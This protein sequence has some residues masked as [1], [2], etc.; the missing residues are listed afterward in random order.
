MRDMSASNLGISDLPMQLLIG[1]C[2]IS[3]ASPIFYSAYGDISSS[4]TEASVE[5]VIMEML[6]KMELLLAGDHGSR[7][8]MD[9]DLQGFGNV[10]IDRVSIGGPLKGGGQ[11]FIISYVLTDGSRGMFSLD[12]PYPISSADNSTLTLSFGDHDLVMIN[13]DSGIED[14][15]RVSLAG[16]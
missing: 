5:N 11:R 1:A 9:L 15:I 12:P 4:M 3:F 10:G 8:S 16:N 13:M 6:D 2:I 14:H 7:T